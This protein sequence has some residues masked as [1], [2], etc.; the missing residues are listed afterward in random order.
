MAEKHKLIM[1]P[2]WC[3][4]EPELVV[5]LCKNAHLFTVIN[6]SQKEPALMVSGKRSTWKVWPQTASDSRAES[7]VPVVTSTDTL[8]QVTSPK[9]ANP[10]PH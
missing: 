8:L 1:S 3:P 7:C 10:P 6:S 4:F 5:I 9:V 2:F